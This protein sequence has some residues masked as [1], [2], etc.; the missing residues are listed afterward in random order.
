MGCALPVGLA[1]MTQSASSPSREVQHQ[2]W[3]AQRRRRCIDETTDLRARPNRPALHCR[4]HIL[5]IMD[6]FWP[7]PITDTVR[8]S[9]ADHGAE[10][11]PEQVEAWLRWIPDNVC[12]EPGGLG[13][14]DPDEGPFGE[15]L[16]H[17]WC[18]LLLVA[19]RSAPHGPDKLDA[20]VTEDLVDA[21]ERWYILHGPRSDDYLDGLTDD[22]IAELAYDDDRDGD[23]EANVIVLP[24]AVF[25]KAIAALASVSVAAQPLTEAYLEPLGTGQLTG[26]A[27]A[28]GSGLH[29]DL[30]DLLALGMATN[31]LLAI[32][33]AVAQSIRDTAG[34]IKVLDALAMKIVVTLSGFVELDLVDDFADTLLAPEFL[35]TI[36]DLAQTCQDVVSRL[37]GAIDNAENI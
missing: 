36:G 14:E 3:A 37:I 20:A 16:P 24:L 17:H 12:T 21:L 5:G 13:R 1:Q 30:D 11:L 27:D 34:D 4:G 23:F 25:T 19:H 22:E 32:T 9:L 33:S 28:A 7:G 10:M 29:P 2:R 15:F 31:E 18:H 26:I 35:G 6:A 8:T